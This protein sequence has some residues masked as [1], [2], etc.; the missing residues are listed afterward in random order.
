MTGDNT[1]QFYR[2]HNSAEAEA[3]LEALK[4]KGMVIR[5]ATVS[6]DLDGEEES[7]IL[8]VEATSPD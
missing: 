3:F 8:A 1:T 7:V 4:H 6:P 5:R 2:F